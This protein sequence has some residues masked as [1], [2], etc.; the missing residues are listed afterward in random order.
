MASGDAVLRY[1]WVA[2]YP[3]S[4]NTWV[5]FLLANL[6]AG[7][8]RTSADI[9]AFC[10]DVHHGEPAAPPRLYRGAAFLKTHWVAP[11]LGDRLRDT[12]GAIYIVRNPLDVCCSALHYLQVPEADR[13]RAIDDFA[14]RLGVEEW[15]TRAMGPIPGN[16]ASWFLVK[17]R[18]P[19]MVL[20]YEDLAADPQAVAARLCWFLGYPAS[21]SEIAAAVERSSFAAM[22]H[23]EERERAVSRPGVFAGFQAQRPGWRFMDRGRAGGFRDRLTDAQID[24]L[25]DAFADV[26]AEFGYALDPARNLVVSSEYPARR[27]LPEVPAIL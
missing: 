21:E 5:R 23:M 26:M 8:V 12:A 10:P 13:P 7:P 17:P 19:R 9:E 22:R 20:R 11:Q 6:L 2:S 14:A 18:F 27:R 1:V 3:K 25:A 4:G 16:I 15:R 24:R